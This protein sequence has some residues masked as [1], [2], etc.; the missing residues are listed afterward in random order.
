MLLM[1]LQMLTFLTGSLTK[2]YLWN[3]Y[4]KKTTTVNSF[5]HFNSAGLLWAAKPF[6]ILT[7]LTW[8][9]PNTET[10][11]VRDRGE[12]YKKRESE[13]AEEKAEEREM[14]KR[15]RHSEVNQ[16]A[17]NYTEN[18]HSEKHTLSFF[19]QGLAQ[20]VMEKQLHSLGNSVWQE[21]EHVHV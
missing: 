18:R 11:T 21:F 14:R 10:N 15:D 20:L 12:W 19:W 3:Y 13:M 8:L 9:H 1:S 4:G 2:K 5:T 6:T 17:A 7:A 16:T